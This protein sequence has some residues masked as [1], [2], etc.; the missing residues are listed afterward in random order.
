MLY[1]LFDHFGLELFR[2]DMLCKK[3]HLL[4]QSIVLLGSRDKKTHRAWLDAVQLYMQCTMTGR[5][6]KH[7]IP[8]HMVC[9][10]F[11]LHD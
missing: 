2:K 8:E 6:R 10:T 11:D 3:L 9:K 5:W 1:I 4:Q 7:E